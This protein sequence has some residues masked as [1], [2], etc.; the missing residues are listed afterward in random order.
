MVCRVPGAEENESEAAFVLLDSSR[1]ESVWVSEL[2]F[3]CFGF[4]CQTCPNKH[5]GMLHT[6]G[7]NHL[8]Q[9]LHNELARANWGYSVRVCVTVHLSYVKPCLAMLEVDKHLSSRRVPVVY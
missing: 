6:T 3:L 8:Y 1:S 7:F 5:P 4:P 2:S 9:F